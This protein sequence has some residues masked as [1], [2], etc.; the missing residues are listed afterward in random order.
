MMRTILFVAFLSIALSGRAQVQGLSWETSLDYGRILKHTP[1][2]LYT[3]PDRTWGVQVN[4]AFQTYGRQEWQQH[5]GY[6][7]MGMALQYFELGDP[8]VL[9]QAIGILPNVSLRI[10]QRPNWN[11]RFQMGSGIALLTRTYHRIDNPT[12]NAIGSTIN[13]LTAFRLKGQVRIRPHWYLLGGVSFSHFSNA[14]AQAPNLGINIPAWT[15]GLTYAPQPVE[16]ESFIRHDASPR[17]QKRWGLHLHAGMAFREGKTPGGPKQP[18]YLGSLAGVYRFTKVHQLLFGIEQEFHRD[19]YLFGL[20]VYEYADRKSAR[21]G[22]SRTMFFVADEL[23]YGPLSI[24]LQAGIYISPAS[25][26]LPWF[27]YNKLGMRYYFP[28]VGKPATQ[29]H[30]GVYLKSHRITAEYVALSFGAEL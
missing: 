24:L 11:L 15:I 29:F 3:I 10:I 9:G 14:S 20:H 25:Q 13:N 4:A 28:P 21:R 7:T 12:N 5:Q 27:L 6:P 2:L 19:N 26:G 30:V 23:K 1:R 16:K 18:V 17:P 22:A 8:Q